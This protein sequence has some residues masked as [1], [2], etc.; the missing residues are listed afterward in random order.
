MNS[1]LLLFLEFGLILSWV[2]VKLRTT[3]SLRLR[4]YIVLVGIQ[5]RTT[6]SLSIK[7]SFILVENQ[8]QDY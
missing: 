7:I 5:L 4:D 6:V 3:V 2:G 1:G 8:T